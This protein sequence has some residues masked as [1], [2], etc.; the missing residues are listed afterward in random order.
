MTG[1]L[2]HNRRDAI[3]DT[4]RALSRFRESCAAQLRAFDGELRS[5]LGV[6]DS[7]LAERERTLQ[8]AREA[9]ANA[10][11]ENQAACQRAVAEAERDVSV[12]Q[13]V[14][15]TIQGEIERFRSR[16]LGYRSA[17]EDEAL[18]GQA[19]L[20]T[21]DAD[22][23]RYLAATGAGG[24]PGGSGAGGS[25]AS[26]GV[27]PDPLGAALASHGLEMVDLATIDFS[28]NPILSWVH[29]TKDDV[30]WA[31]ER[32][33]SVVSK[34][35]ARGGTLDELNA[36]DARDGT[37]GTMRRLG[38]V[39]DTFISDS[40]RITITERADGTFD[41]IDGRHRIETARSLGI[42]SLPMSVKRMGPR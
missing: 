38:G 42:R 6:A 1:D 28:D 30:G 35:M 11:E 39:W 10:S 19:L 37:T 26:S 24:S 13:R 32:W 2:V 20:R 3:A 23:D 17:I 29:A 9:L 14:I 27:A 18:R 4:S 33:D 31:V 15:A 7:A 41:V 21:L 40:S 34:V 22:L 12:A 16:G 5:A 36:R 8:R 25:G